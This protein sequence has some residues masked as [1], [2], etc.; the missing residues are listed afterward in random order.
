MLAG[1]KVLCFSDSTTSPNLQSLARTSAALSLHCVLGSKFFLD[2]TALLE[3]SVVLYSTF[4]AQ[5]LKDDALPLKSA[6]GRKI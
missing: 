5:E 4:C 2:S 6:F 3:R 1:W